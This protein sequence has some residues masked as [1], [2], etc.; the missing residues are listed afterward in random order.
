MTT[1]WGYN[2]QGSQQEAEID[3]LGTK[4]SIELNCSVHYPAFGKNLFECK[5]G[6][7]FP[8]YLVKGGNW[9]VIKKRHNEGKRL[10]KP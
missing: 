10:A 2:L 9:D 3:E 5:C 6:V 4:L 1:G 8:L 7:I